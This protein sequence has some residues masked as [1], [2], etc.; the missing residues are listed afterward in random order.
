MKGKKTDR[1]RLMHIFNAINNVEE[2]L[3][4]VTYEQFLID[5]EKKYATLK[6]IEIIGEACNHLSNDFKE[7]HPA[8]AWRSIRGFRNFSIHEYFGLDFQIVWEIAK[9]DLPE[10]K[11]QLK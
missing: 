2:Y 1:N 7:I 6:Q 5:S 3:E 8:I 4:G 11:E 10:L 9:N